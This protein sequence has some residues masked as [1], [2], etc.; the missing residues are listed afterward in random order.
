MFLLILPRWG[1]KLHLV[2]TQEI[3]QRILFGPTYPPVMEE[4]SPPRYIILELIGK[5]RW[6]GFLQADFQKK[7]GM[8]SRSSFHH[9]KSLLRLHMITKQVR[10][11]VS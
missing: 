3:R 9:V 10:V 5:G 4:V 11:I 2:A 6:V 7:C 1:E 8:D